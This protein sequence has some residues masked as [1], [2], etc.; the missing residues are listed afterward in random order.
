MAREAL[1]EI[2]TQG[3]QPDT[4]LLR[5]AFIA[6]DTPLDDNLDDDAPPPPVLERPVLARLPSPRGLALKLELVALFAAQAHRTGTHA[7]RTLPI[8]SHDS[9]LCWRKLV[10]AYSEATGGSERSVTPRTNHGRQIKSAFD[11]LADKDVGLV[12][13]T[14]SGVGKYKK[15]QFLV[16]SGTLPT[17]T[18]SGYSKP[19]PSDDVVSIPAKFFLNGWVHVLEDAEIAAWL[20]FRHRL[21]TSSTLSG[22]D[23][24]AIYTLPHATWNRHKDLT[25]YGL[26]SHE[27]DENRREDGTMVERS[28]RGNGNLHR[29]AP[30]DEGLDRQAFEVVTRSLARK[31]R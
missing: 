9:S 26:L 25:A 7:L 2:W 11:R 22:A 14:D 16:E 28:E 15:P 13:F 17:G 18:Q 12:E 30:C 6:R 31:Q 19:V 1:T 8:E 29:F 10:L 23:R 5:S 21:M 24:R 20:M 3:R 4:I 27:A